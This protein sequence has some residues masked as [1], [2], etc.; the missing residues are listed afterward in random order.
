[1]TGTL[2]STAAPAATAAT[3]ATAASAAWRA[4]DGL[5]YGALGAPL[6]FVALPMYVHWPALAE[7]TTG[8]SL[9]VL[10]V[11]LMVMRCADALVDPWLGRWADQHFARNRKAVM[12]MT[13]LACAALVL[14]FAG[15]FLAS[16]VVPALVGRTVSAPVWLTWS[17]LALGLAYLGYSV[18]SIV[19]QAWG[20]R[21]GGDAQQR[22]RIV[23][24]REVFALVGVVVASVAPSVV[25]WPVTTLLLVVM[26]GLGLLLLG[27]APWPATLEAP[28]DAAR[29]ELLHPWR[30]REFRALLGVLMLN[31]LASAIPA[32][33]VLFYIRDRLVLPQYEGLFLLLYFVAA[34]CSVPLWTRWVPRLGLVRLWALGMVLAMAVFITAAWL[35]AGAGLGFALVCAGSG[36]ALGADLVA[37]SALLA[38]AVQRAGDAGRAE[39][40]WFGWWNLA[41]KLNLAL[42]A[43]IALPLVQALGYVSGQPQNEAAVGA[44]VMVYAVV[45]CVIK[46]VALALLLGQRSRIQST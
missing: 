36:V 14:G 13:G 21:L 18:A 1:M 40:V 42:A 23:G 20:A 32:T 41:T 6:A 46:A 37:P 31:G 44:L 26:L 15:L 28:A 17:V 35:P 9:A 29:V 43:G 22:S 45:P 30:V 19:H 11:L 16:S 33:L 34:A 2:A 24:S 8:L 25:G 7:R 5:R 38:G 10:G 39:G 4:S 3:A 12:R 27:R